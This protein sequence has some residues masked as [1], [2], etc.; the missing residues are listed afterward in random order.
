MDHLHQP[1]GRRHKIGVEDGD[2]L[3]ARHLQARIERSGLEA[4]PV[5][6]MD[7]HDRMAQR[8]I[9]LHN[10]AAT[11]RRLVG[12]VVQ[13]LDL[14]LVVRIIHGADG[15]HQAVDHE[16]LVED[17]QLHR[18][19]RQFIEVPGRVGIVVL[20]VLEVEVAQR[21]AMNAIDRQDDHDGKVGEQ[22]RRVERVPVVEATERSGRHTAS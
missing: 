11:S 12:R 1:V 17:G 4:M 21:V 18:D 3:A 5:G 22:Q 15:L 19:P 16:L 6:A 13:H 8:R 7:V 14:Q 2:E 9:A 10:A 20:P